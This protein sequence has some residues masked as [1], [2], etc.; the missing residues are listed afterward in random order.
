MWPDK[1]GRQRQSLKEHAQATHYAFQ[2]AVHE[3]VAQHGFAS[4][5][6]WERKSADYASD[7]TFSLAEAAGKASGVSLSLFF[8]MAGVEIGTD[9]ACI[10]T[11]FCLRKL[12]GWDDAM[13]MLRVLE[14]TN[15]K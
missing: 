13:K 9:L 12:C 14:N 5:K 11:A 10:A 8:D 15:Y 1:I 6:V 3:A 2:K 7:R 4:C